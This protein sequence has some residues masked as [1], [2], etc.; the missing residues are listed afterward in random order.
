MHDLHPSSL[1][2]FRVIF[3]V[4][5]LHIFWRNEHLGEHGVIDRGYVGYEVLNAELEVANAD[6]YLLSVSQ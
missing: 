3:S 5:G 4:W 1:L 2:I 6:Y